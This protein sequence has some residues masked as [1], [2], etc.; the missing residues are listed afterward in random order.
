[1]QAKAAGAGRWLL[2]AGAVGLGCGPRAEPERPPVREE[3]AEEAILRIS[4]HWA[5]T[6]VDQK[7]FSPPAK[8]SLRRVKRT[9]TLHFGP[10]GATEDLLVEEELEV[11]GGSTL[12]C[13]TGAELQL[14]AR[15]GRRKGEAAVELTRPPLSLARSCD[16]L[17]PEPL[18]VEPSQRALLV[19]RSDRLVV[20]EPT[21][22]GRAYL[23]TLP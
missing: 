4:E 5:A 8:L 22:D 6:A 23:P 10:D 3:S 20:V 2:L 14:G 18:L 11:R 13:R 15:F 7:L 21:V 16:G 12:R 17:P 9:S 1:M 19:L